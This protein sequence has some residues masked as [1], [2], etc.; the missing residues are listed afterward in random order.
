MILYVPRFSSLVHVAFQNK[1]QETDVKATEA[2]RKT[3]SSW[4]SQLLLGNR[5]CESS[6]SFAPTLVQCCMVI[7][8]VLFYSRSTET[9]SLPKDCVKIPMMKWSVRF[10]DTYGYSKN[11]KARLVGYVHS[12][13]ASSVSRSVAF[14]NHPNCKKT[15][16]HLSLWRQSLHLQRGFK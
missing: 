11:R 7:K 6:P 14:M 1:R 2:G 3:A 12:F 8:S 9:T 4:S 16:H 5:Q 15:W 10:E 13:L